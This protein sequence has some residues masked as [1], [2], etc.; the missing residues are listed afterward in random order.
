MLN[1]PANTLNML[2]RCYNMQQTR[3][4]KHVNWILNFAADKTH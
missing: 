1:F 3:H 2:M 4:I